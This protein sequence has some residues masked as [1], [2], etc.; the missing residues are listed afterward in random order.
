MFALRFVTIA[1]PKPPWHGCLS[2]SNRLDNRSYF[3]SIG[4]HVTTSHRPNGG[5]EARLSHF[6]LG[7]QNVMTVKH[8]NN[9]TAK[10]ESSRLIIGHDGVAGCKHSMIRRGK[11]VY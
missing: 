3:G 1:E 10:D 7:Y 2:G 6:T 9:Q 5:L 4:G 11:T 8:H